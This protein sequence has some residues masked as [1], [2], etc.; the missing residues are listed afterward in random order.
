MTLV[1][2]Q[3]IYQEGD[4]VHSIFFLIK[5]MANMVLPSYEN[6]CYVNINKGNH[7]GIMDIIGSIVTNNE[8]D[9]SGWFQRKELVHRQFTV[10]A[11]KDIECLTLSIQDLNRMKQEFFET[12]ELMFDQQLIRLKT[13]WKIK[14]NAM[15]QCK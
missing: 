15:K 2:K 3:Y 1:Q 12:Y 11:T 10:L 14:L 8:L 4:D 9:F 6:A 13:I 5:G 7:F